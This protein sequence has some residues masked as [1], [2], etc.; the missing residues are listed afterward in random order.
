[1]LNTVLMPISLR[2]PIACF[3]APWKRGANK[4]PIPTLSIHSLTFSAGISIFTPSA[5]ITSALPHLLDT[6]LLPCF[7]TLNPAPLATKA[8]TVD[9]LN[10]LAPSPPVPQVSTV[11]PLAISI[12]TDFSRITIAAPVISSTVSPF[13]LSA[14]I[15]LP[16]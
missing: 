6:P 15:K 1:M 3:I 9:I 4:N 13:N 7:A 11:L 16:I 12:F 10:V 14:V 2:G 5:F 8:L